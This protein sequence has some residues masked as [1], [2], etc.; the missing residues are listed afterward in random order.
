MTDA[1][2]YTHPAVAEEDEPRYL[3]RQKPL[4]IK[5]RKFGKRAWKTYLRATWFAVLGLA[6]A[7]LAFVAGDFL[8]TSPR[9][10]LMHPGQIA[11]KGNHYASRGSVLE[12]F[13]PDRGRSILLIPLEERRRQLEAIPWVEQAVVRR[14]LPNRLQ[15][16]IV[17]RTPVAF[18][19][20]NSDLALIDAHGVLLERP[21]EG[22]FHFPV[23]SGITAQMPLEDRAQRMQMFAGFLQQI[24]LAQPGASA[25]V[26]EV[27]LS[28]SHDVRATLEGLAGGAETAAGGAPAAQPF[29]V[30]FGDRDFQAKYKLLIDNMAHWQA[31]AGRVESVDLRFAGQ[32]VVNPDSSTQLAR[33]T[34]A[35]K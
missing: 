32:I 28:E 27:D 6:F 15:V 1:D 30:L 13:R 7:A 18:L 31:V 20:A 12:V 16:E 19:R 10:A 34:S 24:D 22:D 25:R 11:L 3:R 9:M 17:E 2:A 21:L 23:V 35:K 33:G 4:E 29:V 26:S 8:L 14:S 5:R